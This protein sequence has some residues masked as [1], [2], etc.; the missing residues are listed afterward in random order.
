[1]VQNSFLCI[2]Q[3]HIDEVQED[4]KGSLIPHRLTGKQENIN[5]RQRAIIRV[6]HG[7]YGPSILEDHTEARQPELHRQGA[8]QHIY[9][10]KNCKNNGMHTKRRGTFTEILPSAI[11]IIAVVIRRVRLE[12]GTE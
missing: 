12:D 1:M 9:S 5:V 3:K 2:A 6:A 10:P 11:L 8:I 7:L 4:Q